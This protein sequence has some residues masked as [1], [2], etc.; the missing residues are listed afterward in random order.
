MK[1]LRRF[2][3]LFICLAIPVLAAKSARYEKTLTK[4]AEGE[5]IEL[6][7][8][9]SERGEI[10]VEGRALNMDAIGALLKS[11]EE[12]PRFD[13]VVLQMTWNEKGLVFTVACHHDGVPAEG[14]KP[15]KKEKEE[16]RLSG[17][18][19]TLLPDNALVMRPAGHFHLQLAESVQFADIDHFPL[20]LLG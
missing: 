7:S 20:V 2:I 14:L 10:Q 19:K 8:V 15:G 17:L 5:G 11:L 9:E 1:A 12:S 4:L 13:R 6:R 18:L 3:F 16:E